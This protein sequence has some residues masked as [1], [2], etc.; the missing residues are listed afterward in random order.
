MSLRAAGALPAILLLAGLAGQAAAHTKST[1]YSNWRIEGAEVHLSFTVPLI[2]S[3]RLN[4]PGETQ[5]PNERIEDYLS[6]RL[7]VSADGIACPLTAPPRPLTATAQFRRFEMSYRCPG[8]EH[9]ALH[10]EVFIDL[11][12]SHVSLAQIHTSDGRLIQQLFTKDDRTLATSGKDESMRDAGFLRYVQMGIMHIF[13]GIDHMSF[14]LGLVLISRRLRDLVYAVTGFTIGHSATL[15]LAV[16]GVIRPH[17]EFI[18]ALVALTIAMIGAENVAVA[19]HRPGIVAGGLAGILLLMAIGSFLGFGGLPVL[20]LL[21]AG[22]FAANY[23]M[24][25]GHLREAARLRIVV[26]IVFGLIHGF[27]FAADLLE[28]RLPS[29]Q[30]VSILLGFNLGVEIGQLTLVLAALGVVALL[31]RAKLALP[32][33]IVVDTVS[34]GLV[35]LGMYWFISR[36]FVS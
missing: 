5:P 6:K 35:G 4:E 28:L 3:A 16:T 27:G 12:P 34:A 25:S 22:L 1:S 21:G 13:T 9:I 14:L 32:R 26:T 33:P 23:L 19:T 29:G 7:T 20:L 15:A 8:D 30:L 36:N 10:S 31:V 17:T 24:L 11:V 18:D 2:E